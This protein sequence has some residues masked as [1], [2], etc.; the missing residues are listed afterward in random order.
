[1]SSACI[2]SVESSIDKEETGVFKLLTGSLYSQIFGNRSWKTKLLSLYCEG[3]L[4]II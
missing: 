4:F 1:M 2:Y 3:T